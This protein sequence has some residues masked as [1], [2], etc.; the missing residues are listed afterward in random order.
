MSVF[1]ELEGEVWTQGASGE[2]VVVHRYQGGDYGL[3]DVAEFFEMG[4]GSLDEAEQEVLDIT[5]A[6]L[7]KLKVQA[8]AYSFDFEEGLIALCLDLHRYAQARPQ[9]RY[10]F[11]ADF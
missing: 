10:R 9:E 11:I 6:E 2:R 5:Q 1:E 4:A 3:L 7:D 8:D